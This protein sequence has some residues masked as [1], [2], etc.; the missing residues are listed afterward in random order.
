MHGRP[1]HPPSHPPHTPHEASLNN[2]SHRA[3]PPHTPHGFG[4]ALSCD[5]DL[6]RSQRF[7]CRHTRARA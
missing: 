6:K 1:P 5:V 2:P 7:T 4:D 3:V